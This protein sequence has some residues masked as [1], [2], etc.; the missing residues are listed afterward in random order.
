M[1]AFFVGIALNQELNLYNFDFENCEISASLIAS[2]VSK[3]PSLE[4]LRFGFNVMAKYRHARIMIQALA[5]IPRLKIVF[6]LGIIVI[7][8]PTPQLFDRNAWLW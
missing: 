4:G 6:F 8:T 2:A 7:S 3:L 5:R 1:K